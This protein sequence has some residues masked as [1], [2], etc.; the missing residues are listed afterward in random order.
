MNNNET[1]YIINLVSSKL[2]KK[3]KKLYLCYRAT[4]DGDK[5]Q[6]FHYKCDYIKNILILIQTKKNKK[7]GG[8]STESW[9]NN[10][11]KIWKKDKQA[12][13]FSLNKTENRCY[14][15]KKPEMA[16]FCHKKHGPIFGNGEIL[17]SDNFFTYASTCLEFHTY[18]ESKGI[19]FPLNG[20]KEFFI[21]EMEAYTF[22]FEK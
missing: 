12:F 14:N 20:E 3:I 17:I 9:D 4:N 6:N 16:L 18:Y 11:E 10:N 15:I 2:K 19:S 8:F 13:I 5:A 1:N 7:F 21:K 22:D